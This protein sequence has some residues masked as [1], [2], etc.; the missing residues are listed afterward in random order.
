[1]LNTY[2]ILK[3][4]DLLIKNLRLSIVILLVFF[5]YNLTTKQY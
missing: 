4:F 1:M 5:Y 3:W 2:K